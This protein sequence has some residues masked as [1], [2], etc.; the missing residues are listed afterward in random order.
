MYSQTPLYKAVFPVLVLFLH[1]SSLSSFKFYLLTIANHV[2]NYVVTMLR[3][4]TIYYVTWHEKIVLMC[5]WN[6]ITYLDFEVS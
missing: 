3:I 1:C 2:A 5:T 6:L 4:D